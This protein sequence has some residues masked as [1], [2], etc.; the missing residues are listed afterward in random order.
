MPHTRKRYVNLPAEWTTFKPGCLVV[1]ANNE[2]VTLKFQEWY[3]ERD[4]SR[5]AL[6]ID[7]VGTR[8]YIYADAIR[9]VS[10]TGRGKARGRKGE[11]LL[12]DAESKLSRAEKRK[13]RRDRREPVE[14]MH[15]E[16]MD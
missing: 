2:E 13:L 4:G 10:L 8:R 14:P 5:A 1:E 6:C 16:G 9:L 15:A 12:S 7:A 3:L 11:S